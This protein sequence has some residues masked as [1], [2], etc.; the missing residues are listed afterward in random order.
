MLGAERAISTDA[1]GSSPSGSSRA[2][3]VAHGAR[4]RARAVS[5][6]STSSSSLDTPSRQR[7]PEADPWHRVMAVREPDRQACAPDRAREDRPELARADEACRADLAVAH[8]HALRPAPR[9]RPGSSADGT[10]P[11][12]SSALPSPPSDPAL[13]SCDAI[14]A[15]QRRVGGRL[16]PRQRPAGA[17]RGAPRRGSGCSRH[18]R[19]SHAGS[20]SSDVVRRH[21]HLRPSRDRGAAVLR[22][23]G[24]VG[25]VVDVAHRLEVARAAVRAAL[26]RAVGR[27]LPFD[28]AREVLLEELLRQAGVEVVPWQ[29]LGERA[30]AEIELGIEPV[31][32]ER[33]L[34]ER[35]A[36]AGRTSRRS[37]RR[38]PAPSRSRP[39]AGGR[40]E[41][42][43]LRAT[44]AGHRATR[45]RCRA[46]R[47]RAAA[48]PAA[49]ASRRPRAA[50]AHWNGVC[51]FGENV[52]TLAVTAR[53]PP[54]A[55]FTRSARSRCRA[56]PPRSRSGARS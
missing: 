44:R 27:E 16:G 25:M 47:A 13:A 22:A 12:H 53:R 49:P 23:L 24:A 37:G 56:R 19:V 11:S 43:R 32:R 30:A 41:R 38:A 29:R 33:L 40:R 51:G 9:V 42:R 21:E 8:A 54:A 45:T 46:V 2:S 39:R 20:G 28:G 1:S 34:P 17:R 4:R 50:P 48:A 35:D 15:R 3:A 18:M 5:S 14:A 7:R 36:A 31:R 52:D 26:D 6:R 55:R 10:A